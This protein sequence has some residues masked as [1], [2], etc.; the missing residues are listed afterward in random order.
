MT[1]ELIDVLFI[2][3]SGLSF[4]F[5]GAHHLCKSETELAYSRGYMDALWSIQ[6]G[7][8]QKSIDN[9]F[10]ATGHKKNGCSN[11]GNELI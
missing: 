2:F 6:R 9:L 10:G 11:G 8:V 7:G 1:L 3:L 5:I 4:G